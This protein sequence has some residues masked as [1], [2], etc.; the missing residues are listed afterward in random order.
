MKITIKKQITDLVIST[1]RI[2]IKASEIEALLQQVYSFKDI[3]DAMFEQ[4]SLIITNYDIRANA[5]RVDL[6]IDNCFI[7]DNR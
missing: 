6:Y 2:D 7:K 4:L 1:I 5:L 3:Y